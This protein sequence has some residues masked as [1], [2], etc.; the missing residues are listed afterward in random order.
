M[1]LQEKIYETLR[2]TKNKD[3][4]NAMRILKAELQ[5]EK[6]K[7]VS[8]ARIITIIRSLIKAEDDRLRHVDVFKKGGSED[9]ANGV[10]YIHILSE[11]IPVQVGEEQI[12]DW[13]IENIDFSEYKNPLQAMKF[14]IEHFGATRVD[15]NTVKAVINDIHTEPYREEFRKKK[16]EYQEKQAKE[17]LNDTEEG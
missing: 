2:T 14:I 4:K 15:G 3:I 12:R 9:K 10:R 8:D 7:D 11:L 16:A 17:V 1:T 5:R 6:N 13:I